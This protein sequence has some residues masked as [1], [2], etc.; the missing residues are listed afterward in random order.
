MSTSGPGFRL[1]N[2]DPARPPDRVVA[3][4]KELP[5]R[6]THTLIRALPKF[7]E[8]P[9]KKALAMRAK[10]LPAPRPGETLATPFPPANQSP[11]PAVTPNAAEKLSV[12]RFAPEGEV[13][14]APNLSVTFSQ[15]MVAVTSVAD[16]AKT[17]PPVSLVPEPPG[18]WRWIGTQTVLFEPEERF[19]M[20]TDY[21]VRIASGTTAVSGAALEQGT[22]FEFKTPSLELKAHLPTGWDTVDLDQKIFLEFDQRIDPQ[23]LMPFVALEGP[24]GA[25]ELR[26]ATPG[27]IGEDPNLRRALE[28]A[29]SDRILA[30]VP[31]QPL[32][33]HTSYALHIQAKAP[34]A[35][36]PKVTTTEQGFG[37]STYGPLQLQGIR[38]GW[39]EDCPPL[40]PWYLEFSN[41]IDRKTFDPE[42]VKVSPPIEGL[43]AS[44]SGN[45]VQLSGRT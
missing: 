7:T 32:Q 37:F 43:R 4:T 18:K 44:V 3:Q 17:K 5:L 38:C 26:P 30:L 39:G 41:P 34:T 31:T 1:R 14:L 20:A 45:V 13:T 25:V 24:K 40:T 33:K 12:V 6:R 21:R 28:R 15:P 29:E 9:E 27:E 10:S 2:A 35:E 19:P 16:L 22:E 11:K 23:K 36:G 8:P 42:Q